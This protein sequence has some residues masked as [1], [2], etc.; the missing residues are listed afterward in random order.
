MGSSS[1]PGFYSTP[2]QTAWKLDFSVDPFVQS[3][4]LNGSRVWVCGWSLCSHR[5]FS[6]KDRA[7]A[8][9]ARVHIGTKIYSCKSACGNPSWY[10]ADVRRLPPCTAP[11]LSTTDMLPIVCSLASFVSKDNLHAHINPVYAQ[12]SSWCVTPSSS[13]LSLN[14]ALVY[15]H[16]LKRIS[17]D[18]RKV[19]GVMAARQRSDQSRKLIPKLECSFPVLAITGKRPIFYDIKS[20]LVACLHQFFCK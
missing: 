9:V 20:I 16:F 8:H 2:M 13:P 1:S 17:E 19:A 6:R 18:M 10:V 4:M 11:S 15:F 3:S 5:P 7:V 12:C 14:C